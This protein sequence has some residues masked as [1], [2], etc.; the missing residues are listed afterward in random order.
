MARRPVWFARDFA[1]LAPEPQWSRGGLQW[2]TLDTGAT[3]TRSYG[4][5]RLF[6]MTQ[7]LD[8]LVHDYTDR[9]AV[10]GVYWSGDVT[11][12]NNPPYPLS[13]PNGVDWIWRD[14]MDWEPVY[15]ANALNA[16]L[17]VQG[18]QAVGRFD[19]RV[20]RG[21]A[22]DAT[23]SMTTA[24]ELFDYGSAPPVGVVATYNGLALA[25]A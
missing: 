9:L 25:P 10:F 21:P 8:P 2:S 22:P 19:T 24:W 7:G 14:S 23:T 20:Q 16:P 6:M 11:D 1:S 4:S 15:A 13:N 18:Y 17:A 3:L 5:I 12:P